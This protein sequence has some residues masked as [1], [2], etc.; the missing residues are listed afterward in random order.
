VAGKTM[1]LVYEVAD[2]RQRK[3]LLGSLSRTLSTGKRKNIKESKVDAFGSTG[4][5]AGAQLSNA[6]NES[7]N[8]M[9]QA[10]NDMGNPELVY[11]FLS[12]A[13]H[14]SAW[15]SRRGAAFGITEMIGE[16]AIEQ[17]RPQFPKML[18]RLYR[19]RF[20]PDPKTSGAMT[21]LW[22]ALCGGEEGGNITDESKLI[23]E[24]FTPILEGTL[25][26]LTSRH[27]RDRL[28]ACLALDDLLLIG[29]V[30]SEVM[31]S[32]EKLWDSSLKMADDIKEP[33]QKGGL[34]LVRTLGKLTIRLA[35]PTMTSHME[36][37]QTLSI[38]LPFFLNKGCVDACSKTRA[39]S[40]Y[41]MLKVVK[42]AGPL[43][44]P[45]ASDVVPVLLEYLSALESSDLVYLQQH[46]DK[47]K[48]ITAEQLEEIRL[49]MASA[50][51]LAEAMNLCLER[52]CVSNEAIDKLAPSL[53]ALVQRGTGLATR[54]MSAR[55]IVRLATSCPKLLKSHADS[56]LRPL[57]NGLTDRSVTVRKEFGKAIGQVA[58]LCKKRSVTRLVERLLNDYTESDPSDEKTRHAAG[59]ALMALVTTAPSKLKKCV[60]QLIPI[61]FIAKF[62]NEQAVK[63]IWESVWNEITVTTQ[64]GI[65][66]HLKEVIT[67]VLSV[68][69]A[70]SHDLRRQGAD[71]LTEVLKSVEAKDFQ[72]TDFVDQIESSMVSA[73][74][75]RFWA[76]KDAVL[77]ATVA[78]ATLC[79]TKMIEKIPKL[80]ERFMRECGRERESVVY[81]R[82]SVTQLGLLLNAAPSVDAYRTGKVVVV[83]V[84]GVFNIVV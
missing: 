44:V 33:V 47:M 20:D 30:A 59:V 74:T 79:P 57:S 75:G 8:Q 10:A 14:H 16:G 23:R 54:A 55:V 82:E 39:L 63:D 24:Y 32:I 25:P 5:P 50:G 27:W 7:Y 66:L 38:V 73:L 21:R 22:K 36:A 42:V 68:L 1:S 58:R 29:R 77:K 80:V 56:M 72:D 69:G 18:P 34:R 28:S 83:V 37:A 35:D 3:V 6:G 71:A 43:L 4:G 17:L 64:Q 11:K 26:A 53:V 13:S 31:P 78:L 76:G 40:M 45:H 51:P 60:S 81:S 84:V 2:E 12:F 65:K 61:S 15:H 48:N 49:R 9:C 62:S 41:F 70:G 67:T 46:T 19:A 52:C